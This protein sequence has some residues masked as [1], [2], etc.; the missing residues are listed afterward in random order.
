MMCRRRTISLHHVVEARIVRE[1]NLAL[2]MP[3][4]IE[5][6]AKKFHVEVGII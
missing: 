5:K 3:D 2:M 4:G 6:I 1:A